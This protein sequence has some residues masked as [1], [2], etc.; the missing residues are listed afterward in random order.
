MKKKDYRELIEYYNKWTYIAITHNNYT[1]ARE[2]AINH[3]RAMIVYI[4][5][6]HC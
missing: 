6:E 3:I 4:K 5:R 1:A 2:S